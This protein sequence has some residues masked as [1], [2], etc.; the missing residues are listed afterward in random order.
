MTLADGG[1]IDYVVDGVGARVGRKRDGAWTQRFVWGGGLGPAAEVDAT[2]DVRTQFVYALHGHVPAYMVRDGVTY[3]LVLDRRGSVRRV[4]DVATGAVAQALDYDAYGRVV[5]DTAPGF[6]PFG[7]GGGLYDP[8]TG[9]VRFGARDYDADAGRWTAPDPLGFSG[10][11]AN[12]YAYVGGDPVNAVDP[13]GL[14]GLMDISEAAAGALN[15]LTFGASNKI[16]GIDDIDSDAYRCGGLGAMFNPRG[17]GEGRR[18]EGGLGAFGKKSG[19]QIKRN[20]KKGKRGE[21][22]AGATGAAQAGQLPE[23]QGA[24]PRYLR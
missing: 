10:G 2:G 18:K 6:Q 22:R 12:L 17:A 21:R 24:L 11:D 7:F 19:S 4:V 9:L 20:A 5:R 1:R 13:V 15:E 16:A 3:R 23:R 14:F 8:E